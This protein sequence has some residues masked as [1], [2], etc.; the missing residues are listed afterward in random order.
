MFVYFIY[1]DNV[2]KVVLRV[3]CL[4]SADKQKPSPHPSACASAIETGDYW[5]SYMLLLHCVIVIVNREVQPNLKTSLPRLTILYRPS[6]PCNFKY[7]NV[8]CINLLK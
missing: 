2:V 7:S 3:N 5:M 6:L 8:K 1:N 4:L